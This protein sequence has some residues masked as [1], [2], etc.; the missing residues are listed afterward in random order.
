MSQ[1]GIAELLRLFN[2]AYVGAPDYRKAG[3][4]QVMAL[5]ACRGYDPSLVW[6]AYI[7]QEAVGFCMARQRGDRGRITG[8]GVTPHWRRKGIG[9]SLL[10]HAMSELKQRGSRAVDLSVAPGNDGCLRIVRDLGF[11]EG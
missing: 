9:T 10:Q 4:V 7:G 3:W 2:T 8:I 6:I 5:Q 1:G 11:T